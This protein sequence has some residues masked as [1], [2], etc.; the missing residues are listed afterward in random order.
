MSWKK[1][2]QIYLNRKLFP[3]ISW[4]RFIGYRIK[5]INFKELIFIDFK[6]IGIFLALILINILF[7]LSE[8]G[9]PKEFLSLENCINILETLVRTVVV[10]LSIIF[11]FT[12]L[13]FQIFNKYFGRFAFFDFF[14]KKHLKIMFTLFILNVFFLMYAIGY[15]KTCQVDNYFRT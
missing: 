2:T 13:S 14:R 15:L 10:L 9:F 7:N 11:S 1:N 4:L 12:L 5:N 6:T 3:I 8:I